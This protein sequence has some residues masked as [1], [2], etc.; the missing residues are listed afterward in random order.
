MKYLQR[1]VT[2]AIGAALGVIGT[3]AMPGEASAQY[4]I[5]VTNYG[6]S[7]NGMPFAIA[8]EKKLFEAEGIEVTEILTSAGGGTTLRNMLAADAP[9]AEINPA[10]AIGAI[11]EGLN[12]KIIGE[13]VQTVA[14]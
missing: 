13:N 2:A 4:Q 12:L 8:V 11:Q 7:A 6:V 14:E 3:L 5:V 9:Y 1:A 10:A